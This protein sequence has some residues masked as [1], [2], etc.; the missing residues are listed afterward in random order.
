M[1]LTIFF[2][3]DDTKKSF[4]FFEYFPNKMDLTFLRSLTLLHIDYS[5]LILYLETVPAGVCERCCKPDSTL[6]Q[7]WRALLPSPF[8][9]YI[10]I[11]IGGEHCCHLYGGNLCSEG[12]V[13]VSKKNYLR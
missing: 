1:F 4:F 7:W 8:I 2:V 10:F 6:Q 3:S 9:S 5:T 11:I 12:E 13:L